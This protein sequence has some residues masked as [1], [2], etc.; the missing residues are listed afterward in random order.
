MTSFSERLREALKLR[1]YTQSDLANATGI[2]RNSIHD[3]VTAKYKPK[4]DNLY[5]I[6]RELGV[7]ESW[8]MGLNVPRERQADILEIF[9][10]LTK[11]NQQAVF[12]YA[13]KKLKGQE[14]QP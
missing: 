4:Q 11:E 1:N 12:K 10:Q 2:G 7:S 3:Y 5:L 14:K 8:L 9:K 6:A 13:S